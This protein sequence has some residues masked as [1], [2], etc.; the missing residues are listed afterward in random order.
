MMK[1]YGELE[2]DLKLVQTICKN[3]QEE[4]LSGLSF[5]FVADQAS[6]LRCPHKE[7]DEAVKSLLGN[8]SKQVGGAGRQ[9]WPDC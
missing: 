2:N 1:E 5:T 6:R 4:Y 9:T 7:L 3:K 8:L